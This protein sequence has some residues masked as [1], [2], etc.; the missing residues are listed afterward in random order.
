[1]LQIYLLPS[2]PAIEQRSAAVH[3]VRM[4]GQC[5]TSDM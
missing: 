2:S 5:R 3:V 4:C 1:M